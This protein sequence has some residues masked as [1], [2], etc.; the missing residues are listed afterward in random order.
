MRSLVHYEY[1]ATLFDYPEADYPEHVQKAYALLESLYPLAAAELQPFVEALEI[2]GPTYTA[3]ALDKIQ[4]IF[5][6]SFDVQAITT[7]GVGYVMFGDD[8]KRGELFVNLSREYADTGIDCGTELADHLPTVL[9]LIAVWEDEELITELVEE[10]LH[11][12]LH[13]MIAEF[14]SARCQQRDKLYQKH[15]KT[16]ISSSKTRGTMFRAPLAALLKVLKQ[17]FALS[18]WQP[19]EQD[20][21]FLQSLGR[22]LDIEA[23]AG[24]PAPSGRM[25]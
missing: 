13:Q 3:E 10:L 7:L 12:A 11:P 5:T 23:N 6:R 22:E 15:Y 9:R 14:G 19:P 24:K 1:L 17:D 20:N 2:D 18:D 21:D 16:L 8:Y 25:L 4:E